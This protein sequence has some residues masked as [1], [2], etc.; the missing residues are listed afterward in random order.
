MKHDKY[1]W[2]RGNFIVL[3]K[4]ESDKIIKIHEKKIL[5]EEQKEKRATQKRKGGITFS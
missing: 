4:K 2:D 5:R 1:M 3:S